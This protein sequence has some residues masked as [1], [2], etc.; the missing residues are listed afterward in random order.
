[1][2]VQV[3]GQKIKKEEFPVGATGIGVALRITPVFCSA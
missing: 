1:M 2:T 3:T